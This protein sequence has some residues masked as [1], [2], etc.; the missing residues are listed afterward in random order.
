[1]YKKYGGFDFPSVAIELNGVEF[2]KNKNHMLVNDIRV[3]LTSGFEASI[4]SF[5]IY[6]AYVIGE[7]GSDESKY[8]FENLKKQTI[9]G[10]SANIS[11]GYGSEVKSVFKGFIASVDFCFVEDEPPYIEVTAMDVKG[12]MMASSYATQVA[13][14]SYGEAVR[15]LLKRVYDKTSTAN[16]T[17]KVTVTDTPDKKPASAGDKASAETIEMV[18][19][20]DYEFVVKAA[21]KFNYEFFVDRGNLLFRKARSEV[22]PL[23]SLSANGG[24]IFYRLG[25]SLT[26]MVER[27]EVRAIDPGTGK[28]LIAK[29]KYNEKLSTASKA[30]ALI[31]GS[32]KVYIDPTMFS[33][34]QADA[35]LESLMAQMSYRLGSLECECVGMPDLIPG[36][37]MDISVGSPGDNLFYITNVVHE[38]NRNGTYRTKLTGSVDKVRAGKV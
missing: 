36:R 11:L 34:A 31:K 32:S 10:A 23:T 14:K 24:I 15:E 16:I 4:A 26:G 22:R 20:S 38:L 27:I 13:A 19:E 7:E 33:Q 8:L 30:K 2:S 12:I 1:M 35:R 9:L 3:E 17:E 18:S 6:N 21:K 37:F 29:D 25:Y 28:V 5:R